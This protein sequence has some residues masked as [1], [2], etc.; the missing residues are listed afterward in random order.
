MS[1]N[2]PLHG[3]AAIVVHERAQAEAALAL[4]EKLGVP[5]ALWSP[6][7]AAAYM[8][9]AYFQAMLADAL[10]AHPGAV[11]T[12]VLDC[13]ERAGDAR[14]ALRQGIKAVCFQGTPKVAAKLRDMARQRGAMVLE[15]RPEALD[16][17]GVEDA[18]SACRNWLENQKTQDR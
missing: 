11:V 18:E 2:P 1:Q 16:L 8:G 10:N 4:A 17:A 7:G 14:G 6:P 12:P 13:G 5:V 9:A 15:A 3:A